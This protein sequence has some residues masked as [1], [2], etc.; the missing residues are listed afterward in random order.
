MFQ[1]LKMFNFDKLPLAGART[2]LMIFFGVIAAVW[3]QISDLIAEGGSFT[4]LEFIYRIGMIIVPAIMA[5][6][7]RHVG[8]AKTD[9]AL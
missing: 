1:L 6:F 9:T 8:D 2:Y 3:P 7:Y 5:A 4:D